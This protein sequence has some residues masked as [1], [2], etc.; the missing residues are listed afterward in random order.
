MRTRSG[1]VLVPAFVLLATVLTLQWLPVNPDVIPLN[2]E[3]SSWALLGGISLAALLT[4]DL[5]CVGAGLLVARGQVEFLS[6][7]LACFIGF[8][9]GN[10]VLYWAGS[11]LGRICLHRAP[12]SW[13]LSPDQV[14]KSIDWF[15]RRGAAVVFFTRFVPGTRVASYFAAGLMDV[16]F[17]SFLLYLTLSTAIWVPL[18]VGLASIL[19][20]SILE[21][22]GTFERWALPVT[23]G[24][25]LLIWLAIKAR[26]RSSGQAQ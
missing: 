17:P 21:I 5:A 25:G 19:G 9:V 10:I 26:Q 7:C 12:V 20:S 24:L 22:F 18:L 8:M 3:G 11:A 2:P 14:R 4:E 6:A 16:R 13:M 15:G 1:W 23:L